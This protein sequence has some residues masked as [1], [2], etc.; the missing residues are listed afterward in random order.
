MKR[1]IIH[2]ISTFI[3]LIVTVVVL[4]WINPIKIMNEVKHQRKIENIMRRAKK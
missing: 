2:F 4:I 1:R 3:A